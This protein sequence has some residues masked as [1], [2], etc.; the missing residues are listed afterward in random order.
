MFVHVLHTIQHSCK[1][2][3]SCRNVEWYAERGQTPEFIRAS[4]MPGIGKE[5][6]LN[7]PEMYA[8]DEIILHGAKQHI[9]PAKIPRYFDKIHETEHLEELGEIKERRKTRAINNSREKM[10]NT[11]LTIQEQLQLEKREK[12]DKLAIFKN[13]EHYY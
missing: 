6:Y 11:S 12:E 8:N 2:F 9:V 10:K 4:R 3:V 5:Y 13:R 1:I 7:H